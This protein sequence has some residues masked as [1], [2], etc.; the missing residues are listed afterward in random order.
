VPSN[1]HE[2]EKCPCCGLPTVLDEF[3]MCSSH[4]EF[5]IN[6]PGI[7]LYFDFVLLCVG[8]MLL[9]GYPLRFTNPVRAMSATYNVWANWDGE[10]CNQ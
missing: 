9:Y 7:A 1:G 10:R 6:G 4:T 5:T 2:A 8:F 3:S